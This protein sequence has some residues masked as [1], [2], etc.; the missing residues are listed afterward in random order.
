[1][2]HLRIAVIGLAAASIAWSGVG[3]EG[4]VPVSRTLTTGDGVTI[5]A[6]EY[7][8][9]RT[10]GEPFVLLFHQGGGSGPA[11]YAPIAPRIHD[12]GFNVL[13]IDQRR[14]GDR[15][16]ARNPVAERF[17][18]AT[19]SY[20]AVLPDL[21]AALG[22]AREIEPGQAAILWGSSY[23]AALVIQLGATRPDDVRGV[24]AFS[25]ASGDPMDGCLPEP[26]AERL[27]DPLLVIRPV[28]EMQNER[29]ADQL[30]RFSD[31]GHSTY[32][33]DPGA[34]GSSTLVPERAGGD[35]EDAW[36]VVMDFL[37]RVRGGA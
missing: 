3:I 1:L 13:V 15:F 5:P 37:E 19:T 25:P 34:H 8:S 12:A 27:V 21:E 6:L 2:P 28:S 22:Y 31:L 18:P 16:G 29:A 4:Q 26:F 23:S 14:G 33:A 24:L 10:E 7:R 35:T 17:D 30:S 20:C 11:E 9:E 36:A 32:V